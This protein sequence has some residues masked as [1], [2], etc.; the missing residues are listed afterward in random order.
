MVEELEEVVEEDQDEEEDEDEKE[1]V[2]ERRR[3]KIYFLKNIEIGFR[4]YI[5]IELH[6]N[7]VL[8]VLLSPSGWI[9]IF[10]L[11]NRNR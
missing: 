5:F 4:P 11:Q 3:K 2:E 7:D 9:L 8:E 10:F 1:E 6:L